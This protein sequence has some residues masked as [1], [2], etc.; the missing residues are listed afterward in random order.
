MLKVYMPSYYVLSGRA[1]QKSL[2][3][4]FDALRQIAKRSDKKFH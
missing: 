4:H 2:I 1:E 3:I